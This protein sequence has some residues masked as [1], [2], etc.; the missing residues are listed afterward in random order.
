MWSMKAIRRCRHLSTVFLTSDHSPSFPDQKCGFCS[1][2]DLIWLLNSHSVLSSPGRRGPVKTQ[3]TI[4][5]FQWYSHFMMEA[6]LF[7]WVGSFIKEAN[8]ARVLRQPHNT[9]Q[10]HTLTYALLLLILLQNALNPLPFLG[11]KQNDIS[12]IVLQNVT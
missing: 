10:G 7:A 2:C 6:I 12:M 1:W 9:N 4:K 8:I 3:N 11:D 5:H